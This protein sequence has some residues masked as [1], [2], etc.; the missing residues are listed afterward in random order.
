MRASYIQII[1]IYI[2]SW[3][4]KNHAKELYSKIRTAFF[5]TANELEVKKKYE[6]WMNYHCAFRI[7]VSCSI[8]YYKIKFKTFSL[9]INHSNRIEYCIKTFKKKSFQRKKSSFFFIF[10]SFVFFVWHFHLIY[11]TILPKKRLKQ[12]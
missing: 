11:Y 1:Y 3:M 5:L 12:S 2:P 10:F 9:W 8:S 7:M 4:K 6:C